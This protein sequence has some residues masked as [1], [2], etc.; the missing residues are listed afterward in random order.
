MCRVV[1]RT[2]SAIAVVAYRAGEHAPVTL[3]R[4]MQHCATR[5]VRSMTR[6]LVV[7]LIAGCIACDD[8]GDATPDAA[9]VDAA[10]ACP[11]T[12]PPE[13]SKC[14]GTLSCRAQR[15]GDCASGMAPYSVGYTFDCVEGTWRYTAHGTCSPPR[16]DA[17]AGCPSPYPQN[18]T[19]CTRPVSCRF[20]A[21][22]YVDGH[23]FGSYIDAEC[24]DGTWR[25][26]HEC[27]SARPHN[28]DDAGEDDGGV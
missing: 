3:V 10:S 13:G 26:S 16:F 15:H 2:A 27:P 22:C 23:L 7:L 14:S 4:F 28:L 12:D 24:V 21:D 18:G 17:G 8:T 9:G 20:H 6:V 1:P 25:T 19:S 5:G 11:S